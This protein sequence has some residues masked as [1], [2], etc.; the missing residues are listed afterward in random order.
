MRGGRSDIHRS[1]Y[2]SANE[3]R[4][5]RRGPLGDRGTKRR[6]TVHTG[7]RGGLDELIDEEP[8]LLLGY[9]RSGT[10]LLR[11]SM[12]CHSGIVIP[13]ESSFLTWLMPRYQTIQ[14]QLEP[15]QVLKYIGD[16]ENSRKFDTWALR[17]DL[18]R[19]EILSRHPENYAQLCACVYH[20]YARMRNKPAAKWGDKNN[21]H[22]RHTRSLMELFPDA[23]VVILARDPRDVLASIR[24]AN[25]LGR[26]HPYGPALDEDVLAFA[27][28]WAL[29][30]VDAL[31]ALDVTRPQ[32]LSIIRYESLVRDTES[33][34]R[35]ILERMNLGW[36][37]RMLNAHEENRVQHLEPD[38]T[39]AWK[40]MTLQP[41]STV[42]IGRWRSSLTPDESAEIWR[43]TS[44]ARTLLGMS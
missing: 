20:A 37:S 10:T 6:I 11:L 43:A 39:L 38:L 16:L 41:P 35:S 7:T 8:V 30:Y 27:Q 25:E 13:P 34:L 15:D 32:S 26:N 21:V 40:L 24:D 5:L 1:L 28:S 29:Q 33:T 23:H 17:L 18:V 4:E 31:S 14:P 9:P 2:A 12:T 19:S 3:F 36:D 44:E 42:R 22:I